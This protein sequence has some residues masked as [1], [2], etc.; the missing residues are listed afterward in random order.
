MI[1]RYRNKYGNHQHGGCDSKK[2]YARKLEL[3]LWQKVGAIRNL[4]CQKRFELL[5]PQDGEKPV[6][7]IADF[8][9]QDTITGVDKVED[10]KSPATRKV[11]AY[12]LKRK[13]MLYFHKIRITEV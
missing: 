13:M 2:E 3:E 12:I 11:P 1:G 5:P 10:V 9:Y 6:Y 4:E 7:Y 8:A